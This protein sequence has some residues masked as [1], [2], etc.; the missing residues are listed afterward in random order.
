MTGRHL[1]I[2]A[3]G[4]LGD[5]VCAEPVFRFM[6]EKWK[7]DIV[8]MTQY[9]FL[10]RHL[11]IICHDKPTSFY[12]QRLS[13]ATHPWRDE[14]DPW[15]FH[16]MHTVDYI[17]LR[18]LRRQ[19]PISAKTVQIVPSPEAYCQINE[20]LCDIDRS[21]MV[22]LHPGLSWSSKNLP[23]QCWQSYSDILR[24]EGY[25]VVLVGKNF[26]ANE[27]DGDGSRR[28]VWP[29]EGS[30][31]LTD[32]LNLDEFCALLS[33]SPVLITNDS[34]PVHLASAFDGWIGLIATCR[35][36]SYIFPYRYGSQTYKCR[37]LERR[38]IHHDP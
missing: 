33:V 15:C 20:I 11:P 7:D 24:N 6:T 1:C 21:R 30:L 17:S 2:T 4:G 13:I 5:Q 3:G 9:P 35:D 26:I 36:P 8:V 38:Q 22:L 34:A 25:T 23:L 29:L 12:E 18:L 16:R 10:Y 31:D 27:T 28:G 32:K 37:S 14:N 19:L